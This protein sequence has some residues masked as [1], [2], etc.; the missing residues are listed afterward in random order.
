MAGRHAAWG[1]VDC[2]AHCPARSALSTCAR[3]SSTAY[4]ISRLP[5]A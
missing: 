4:R 1:S 2:R 5:E 3:A